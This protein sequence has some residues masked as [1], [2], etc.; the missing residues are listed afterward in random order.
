MYILSVGKTM[1]DVP[2]IAGEL[3]TFH[4]HTNLCFSGTRVVG[5]AEDGECP[6][7]SVLLVTPPMLHVWMVEHP[8]G[9]FAGI[10]TSGHGTT[11]ATH[12]GE[13]H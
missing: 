5:L 11:C 3:T 6:Q 10:E 9:P 2:D 7:G 12:V 4:D 1:D 8:C 13:D